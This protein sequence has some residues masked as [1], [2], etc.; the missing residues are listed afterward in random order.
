MKYSSQLARRRSTMKTSLS[1]R[2]ARV[3]S[4][5][6]SLDPARGAWLGS[7]V[8]SKTSLGLAAA[9]ALAVSLGAG[10][11]SA[12]EGV[13]EKSERLLRELAA[14]AEAKALIAPLLERS[15]HALERAQNA[16]RA[17]DQRHAGELEVLALEIAETAADV[18]RAGQA[19][20][21][22]GEVEQKALDAETRVVR[23]RALV[24]QTA[25]RRGRAAERLQQLEA[26]KAQSKTKPSGP[27]EK[28][29]ASPAPAPAKAPA[30]APAPAKAGPK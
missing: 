11:A 25:A 18:V 23:A 24:E 22:L 1:R 8:K 29:K 21:R 26:E 6:E 2:I 5:H 16:R 9:A 19:E 4:R 30:P 7:G 12:Q 27:G 13:R 14:K 20:T 17:G 3:E 15:K 28:K 10:S